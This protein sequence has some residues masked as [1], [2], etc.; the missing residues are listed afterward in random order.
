MNFIRKQILKPNNNDTGVTNNVIILPTM[1]TAPRPA[2]SHSTAINIIPWSGSI[3]RH[4]IVMELINTCPI[5]NF[6]MIFNCLSHVSKA[7][8]DLLP[9]PL[10][11][12]FSDINN[13]IKNTEFGEAKMRWL[14]T[15]PVIPAVINSQ[16]DVFGNEDQ[17]CIAGL[18]KLLA[19]TVTGT[20]S[21]A[22]CPNPIISLNSYS[23]DLGILPRS[24]FVTSQV[25]FR[26]CVMQ[27]FQNNVMSRCLR[28]SNSGA[29]CRGSRRYS[30]RNFDNGFPL[31]L[32]FNADLLSKNNSIKSIKDL[33]VQLN[34]NTS[35]NSTKKYELF[36][37]TYGSG[38]YFICTI[39]MS[40]PLM[41]YTG[42][43]LL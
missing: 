32:P 20:C 10:P 33:P 22:N 21:D 8:I 29:L 27:W 17:M 38:G 11:Q 13:H 3:K 43:Y 19:N 34:F 28:T 16:I 18:S 37:V 31:L 26:D 39:K 23:I 41:K 35:C 4:G 7:G 30:Q 14:E 25:Y 9:A 15:L 6:L 42:W 12:V 1:T 24:Q 5:D 40:H 36:A 2:S